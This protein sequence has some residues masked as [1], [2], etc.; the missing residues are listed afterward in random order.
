MLEVSASK[1]AWPVDSTALDNP[2]WS[3]LEGPHRAL[4]GCLADLLWYPPSIAP[5]AAIPVAH[6]LPDLESARHRGLGNSAF[7]VG[8]CPTKLPTGWRFAAHSNILQ[9]FPSG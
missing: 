1:R 4:A 8:A 7:F 6:V 3:S 9:L 5:F 2:V